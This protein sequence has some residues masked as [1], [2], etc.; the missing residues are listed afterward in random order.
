MSQGIP[1]G[2]YGASATAAPPREAL[3][4]L[5]RCDVCVVGGGYTG[6]S[7]ALHLA[8]AGARVILLEAETVGF[9]ASGR[10]GGQIHTGFRKEQ[11]ELESWLGRQHARELWELGAESKALVRE[12]VHTHAID[13]ALKD[14]LVIAAHRMSAA[15]ALE[16]EAEH[17]A[18]QYG[19]T[20]LAMLDAARTEAELGTR[21]YPAS[22]F[23]SGGGHLH[24]L[25]FARGLGRAAETAGAVLFEHS[26]VLA[27]DEDKA[28]VNAR[29]AGGTISSDQVVLACDAFSG[30]LAPQLAPYIGQLESFIV[31]TAPLD[32]ALYAR[33]LPSDAAVADTRH[34][35]DYYRKSEDRR[36]LFAGR[37]SYW[38]V[39]KDVAG[40]VGP[41]MA[42]VFPALTGVAIDYAW[43]GTVGITRTRM[44]HLGRL[45]KRMLFAHGYSGQ[46]VALATLCGKLMSEAAL[47]KPERFD[48]LARVP[49]APFPGGQ[50]LRRPLVAAAL[51]WFKLLD[52][53]PG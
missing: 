49:A 52:A 11:S 28:G 9:A 53:L 26:R 23:D 44:P 5:L 24:A 42:H 43:H 7:A 21:V 46:G 12:L 33:V 14:G 20:Q 31:A 51:A 15:H 19:Y 17:L 30:A 40:M 22:R 29:T 1:Q 10:N 34:V 36:M 3:S 4:G 27:L 18:S 38:R 32:E 6:L 2:W 25:N 8:L 13:C 45:S 39:P 35:L 16:R 50:L 41:R 47:G 48:V 37:E